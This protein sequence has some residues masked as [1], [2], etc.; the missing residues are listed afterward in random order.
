MPELVQ[1][2][3]ACRQFCLQLGY[4]HA[5]SAVRSQIPIQTDD[6]VISPSTDYDR[7]HSVSS[8]PT[9]NRSVCSTDSSCTVQFFL[10]DKL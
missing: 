1:I 9:N 7:T 2:L 6:Q 10:F 3:Y 5:I 4:I 8:D